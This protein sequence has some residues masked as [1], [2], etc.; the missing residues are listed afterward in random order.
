MRPLMASL[1]VTLGLLSPA[2]LE[3]ASCESLATLRL[4]QTTVTA[5]EAIAAGAFVAPGAT[6]PAPGATPPV[7]GRASVFLSAP[8]FCRVAATL[9]PTSDSDIKIEVWLPMAAR[10]LGAPENSAWNGKFQA[11]GNGGWLGSIPYS[12]LAQA[13]TAGYAAAASQLLFAIIAIAAMVQYWFS[14]RKDAM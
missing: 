12:A 6:S 4:P 2:R 14:S 7:T 5:A 9:T 3:A 13:V 10:P 11:V 8:A 1:A